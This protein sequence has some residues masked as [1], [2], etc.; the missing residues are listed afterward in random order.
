MTT[1]SHR[2]NFLQRVK[3][4]LED[5]QQYPSDAIDSDE[6]E[7]NPIFVLNVKDKA[8]VLELSAEM[9]KIVLSSDFFDDAHKKKIAKSDISDRKTS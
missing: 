1:G 2:E 4:I 6:S 3:R 8:R 9:R 5:E 7:I